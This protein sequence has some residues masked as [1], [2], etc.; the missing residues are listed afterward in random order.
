MLVIY[1]PHTPSRVLTAPQRRSEL[2]PR[3]QIRLC[4]D[5]R[6]HRAT[7]HYCNNTSS[8]AVFLYL[9]PGYQLQRASG[10]HG[11]TLMTISVFTSAV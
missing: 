10:V 9:I 2:A 4:R 1:T 5:L 6:R 11:Q 8:L 7:Y 3:L